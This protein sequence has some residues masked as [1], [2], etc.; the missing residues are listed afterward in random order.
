MKLTMLVL[1]ASAAAA[2][3]LGLV[4]AVPAVANA[5]PLL[6]AHQSIRPAAAVPAVG[7]VQCD[8]NL[9]IQRTSADGANPAT[10]GHGP[11]Q[12]L[13]PVISNCCFPTEFKRT[14]Q[15]AAGLVVVPDSAL[16][17]S[18]WHPVT[19]SPSGKASPVLRTTVEWASPRNIPPA[20]SVAAA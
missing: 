4:A 10:V 6:A 2:S 17:G 12:R 1:G 15:T 3:L 19:A 5:A 11:A 7:A 9:C 18:P 14:A 8:G 20:R 16:P 13:S